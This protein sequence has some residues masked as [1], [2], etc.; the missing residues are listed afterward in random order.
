[1]RIGW[2]ADVPPG[3]RGGAEMASDELI[4]TAPEWATIV[5]MEIGGV[6][7]GVDAYV[8]QNCTSYDPDIIAL[9]EQRP[10]IKVIHDTW[11]HGNQRLKAWILEHAALLVCSSPLQR[12][13][14]QGIVSTPVRYI[15]NPLD[16]LRFERAA[17][18]STK[19]SGAVWLN[20]LYPGKGIDR[21]ISWAKTNDVPLDVYGYG[22][23]Q[24]YIGSPARYC[25]PVSYDDV[26][27]VLA[28][29]DTY[30]FLPDNVE[31]FARGVVEAWAAGCELVVNG[32]IGALWWIENDPGALF[33]GVARFWQAAREVMG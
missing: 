21:A 12:E 22:P 16:L 28:Q 17:K 33:H 7:D 15:P 4:A 1:M 18:Q 5:P 31:P 23:T 14:L 11:P 30:V 2:L 6:M 26:P 24:R 8:I 3:Y 25:G 19:R 29:Y 32:N 27:G 13:H 10:V 20:R 9:L